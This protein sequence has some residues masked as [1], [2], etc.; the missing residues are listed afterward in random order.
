[1]WFNR[2]FV[3]ALQPYFVFDTTRR[4]GGV[5][6][7][8]EKAWMAF[9]KRNSSAVATQPPLISSLE[10]REPSMRVCLPIHYVP[11][12]KCAPSATRFLPKRTHKSPLWD[13][14]AFFE[15]STFAL[16]PDC[17]P[18]MTRRFPVVLA[19]SSLTPIESSLRAP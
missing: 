9:E 18:F 17:C 2:M 15:R 4:V 10:S 5:H 12:P 3:I 11:Q 16:L 14:C 8:F 1:M 6:A 13:A 7:I 19:R